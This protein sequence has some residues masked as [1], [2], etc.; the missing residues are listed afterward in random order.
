MNDEQRKKIIEIVERECEALRVL[1][2]KLRLGIIHA[3]HVVLE[4]IDEENYEEAKD[5]ILGIIVGLE[6]GSNGVEQ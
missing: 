5:I 1:H 2:K 6:T 4:K 3:I